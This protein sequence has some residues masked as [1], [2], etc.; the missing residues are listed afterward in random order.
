M[1]SNDQ[2]VRMVGS[3]IQQVPGKLPFI[4]LSIV[5]CFDVGL[6]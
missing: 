6:I 1:V 2:T 5:C 4:L 3:Q